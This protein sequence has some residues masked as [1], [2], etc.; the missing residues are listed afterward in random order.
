MKKD[1]AKTAEVIPMHS[2]PSER[3]TPN[4][5]WQFYL[6]PVHTWAYWDQAFTKEECERIIEIGNDRTQKEA[7]TRVKMLK[8]CENQRLHGFILQTIWIG[9]IENL[10]IL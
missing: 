2:A 4:P 1:N 6:D 7:K 10:Q 9:H 8:K 5:A 3:Q